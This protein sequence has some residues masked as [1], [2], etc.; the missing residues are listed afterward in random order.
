MSIDVT[1]K[2]GGEAGQGIQTVGTLWART[3]HGDGHAHGPGGPVVSHPRLPGRVPP[4][5][6][7]AQDP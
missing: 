1:V 4:V 3:R 7:R 5:H 2:I 6:L